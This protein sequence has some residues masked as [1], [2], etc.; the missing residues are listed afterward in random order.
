MK[1]LINSSNKNN[2]RQ[3]I[4]VEL[5]KEIETTFIVRLPDGKI[6]SRKKKRDILEEKTNGNKK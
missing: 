6:I 1:V 5:L 3:I 2:P 4:E